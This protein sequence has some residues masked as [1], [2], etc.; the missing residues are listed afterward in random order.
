MVLSL[1]NFCEFWCQ[2]WKPFFH[3]KISYHFHAI[4]QCDFWAFLS[5]TKQRKQIFFK[6]AKHCQFSHF[7][8][9]YERKQSL[10]S[11]CVFVYYYSVHLF[12][13][14]CFHIFSIAISSGWL[15]ETQSEMKNYWIWKQQDLYT[16]CSKLFKLFKLLK[17]LNF[18]N[19]FILLFELLIWWV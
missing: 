9:L 13:R 18:F 3:N 16:V 19:V 14:C 15:N 8:Q 1:I 11:D 5:S 4:S 7:S 10:Q 6:A 2:N 12:R 17:L